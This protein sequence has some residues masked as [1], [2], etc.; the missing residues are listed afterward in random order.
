MLNCTNRS[1]WSGFVAKF[2]HEGHDEEGAELLAEA[3][4]QRNFC[5]GE[6]VLSVEEGD[7]VSEEE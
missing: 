4:Y 1:F 5:G 3:E 6:I 2:I 7:V